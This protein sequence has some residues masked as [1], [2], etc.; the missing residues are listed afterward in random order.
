MNK[1]ALGMPEPPN[2]DVDCRETCLSP[3]LEEFT[4]EWYLYG[5]DSAVGIAHLNYRIQLTSS[6]ADGKR[7]YLYED[8]FTPPEG[9]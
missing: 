7:C 9:D 2:K 3:M 4:N 6:H 1:Y 5:E 8:Y